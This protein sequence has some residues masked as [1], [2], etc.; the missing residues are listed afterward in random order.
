MAFAGGFEVEEMATVADT[1]LEETAVAGIEVE[2]TAATGIE[3]VE[4]FAADIA[5]EGKIVV[6]DSLVWVDRPAES[7]APCRSL[8][9]R[10]AARH[11]H[12]NYTSDVAKP[13]TA[14]DSAAGTAQSAVAPVG[15]SWPDTRAVGGEVT[16]E[17]T[18]SRV[19]AA[20]E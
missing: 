4:T 16:S 6:A 12:A 8:G 20:W 3:A 5:V 2:E 15:R 1:G 9:L 10:I 19:S 13:N 14:A 7:T 18:R 11:Q 17:K